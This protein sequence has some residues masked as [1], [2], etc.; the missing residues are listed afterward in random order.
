LIEIRPATERDLPFIFSSWL[1]SYRNES[2][3]ARNISSSV[4]YEW[5]H[6]V[7]ERF[8]ERDRV[9]LIAHAP[10][11]PE[12][13]LGY[14]CAES[15]GNII[16]Y[17]YVKKAFRKMGIAKKLYEHAKIKD[18]CEFTHW[19]TDVNWIMK[20]TDLLIYNPYLL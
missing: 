9:A 3:F 1:R 13:I 7:I 17:I 20:K 10:G 2:K 8:F 5:H 19:T 12:V 16:Q 6:K 14:L 11:E 15:S 18:G 4:F